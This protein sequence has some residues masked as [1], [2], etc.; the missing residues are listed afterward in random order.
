MNIRCCKDCKDRHMNCHSTCK[1]YIEEK[2]NLINIH[3]KEKLDGRY[4]AYLTERKFEARSKQL[5]KY[6]RVHV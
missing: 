2:A 5:R 6:G 3:T 1:Q 4:H